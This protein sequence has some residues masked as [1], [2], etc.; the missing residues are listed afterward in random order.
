MP[1]QTNIDKKNTLTIY[2]AA[3]QSPLTVQAKEK[4]HSSNHI[5]IT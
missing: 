2:S 4:V 5:P 3:E 1:G